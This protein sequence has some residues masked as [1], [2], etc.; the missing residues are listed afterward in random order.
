MSSIFRE[1]IDAHRWGGRG[2]GGHLIYPFKD[3]EKLPHKYAIKTT[4]P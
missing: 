2:G 1:I 3:F 4:P